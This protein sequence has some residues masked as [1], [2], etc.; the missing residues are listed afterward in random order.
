MAFVV[1]SPAVGLLEDE[2][3]GQRNLFEDEVDGFDG[4]AAK[5]LLRGVAEVGIDTKDGILSGT[6]IFKEKKTLINL[7][8]SII[9]SSCRYK[10][11]FATIIFP[12]EDE[13]IYYFES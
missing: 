4:H 1:G 2:F 8:F 6:N 5:T 9:V 11:L 12:P 3:G 13:I 10:I 7:L